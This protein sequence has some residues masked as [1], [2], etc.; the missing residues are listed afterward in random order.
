MCENGLEIFLEKSVAMLNPPSCPSGKERGAIN[1][2]SLTGAT[3]RGYSVSV[4]TETVTKISTF[5]QQQSLICSQFYNS[6]QA[7]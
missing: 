3:W 4:K 7:Q 5:E 2:T 1:F 6:G